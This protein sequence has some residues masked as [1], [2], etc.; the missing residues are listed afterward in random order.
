MLFVE[1]DCFIDKNGVEIIGLHA[2]WQ[3]IIIACRR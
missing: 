3:S 1:M 2:R